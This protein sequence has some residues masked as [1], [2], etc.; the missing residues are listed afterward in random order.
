ML[1]VDESR[2]KLL[3]AKVHRWNKPVCFY[4]QKKS[5]PTVKQRR[6]FI[7]KKEWSEIPVTE[8]AAGT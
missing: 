4:R 1:I 5:L 7:R 2:Y 6:S 8:S 3:Q